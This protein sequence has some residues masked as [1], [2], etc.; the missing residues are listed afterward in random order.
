MFDEIN[1]AQFRF[2]NEITNEGNN[3]YFTIILLFCEVKDPQ[4]E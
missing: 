2:I 4:E 1:S 3:Y